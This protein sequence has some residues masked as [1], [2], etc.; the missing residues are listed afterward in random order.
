MATFTEAVADR[1]RRW[2]AAGVL[3]LLSGCLLGGC[4]RRADVVLHQ[5]FA[6]PS[7]QHLRLE[8]G[9][10]FAATGIEG[11]RCLLD[12]PLPG[13]ADGPRDF[14]IYMVLPVAEGELVVAPDRPDGVRGFLIQEVGQLGGKTE[15]ASG[16]I[17][18]RPVFLQPRLRRLDLDVHC[19]D[20]TSIVGGAHVQID[21]RGLRKFEREFATDIRNLRSNEAPAERAAETA[22]RRGERSP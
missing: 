13:A 15:L 17:Q 20:G 22:P 7:Q 2:P 5:P 14:H 16:T 4:S 6:P 1:S 10:A 21:E 12:F 3:A 8:G 19:A 11:C 9:W 18:W